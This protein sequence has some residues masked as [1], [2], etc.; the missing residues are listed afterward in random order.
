MSLIRRRDAGRVLRRVHVEDVDRSPRAGRRRRRARACRAGSGPVHAGSASTPR[1]M[2]GLTPEFDASR[3]TIANT[4]STTSASPALASRARRPPTAGTRRTTTS[5]RARSASG[6]ARKSRILGPLRSA[7]ARWP[8]A[9][10]V[11]EPRIGNRRRRPAPRRWR[12]R[13]RQRDARRGQHPR[14]RRR[15]AARRRRSATGA[16]RPRAPRCPNAAERQV[17]HREAERS[18]RRHQRLQHRVDRRVRPERAEA[19]ARIATSRTRVCGR[20][21]Q[22][23]HR[24]QQHDRHADVHRVVERIAAGC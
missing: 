9:P 13:P 21:G 18:E 6:R 24:R 7:R 2:V 16:P 19:Q 23:G 12:R 11:E 4:P 22:R 20:P 1:V 17:L 5:G 10:A 14:S 3:S 15:G 8:R